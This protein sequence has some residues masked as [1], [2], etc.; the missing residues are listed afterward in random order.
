MTFVR[1][2]VLF[3]KL[4]KLKLNGCHEQQPETSPVVYN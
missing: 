1:D 3:K 4:K 2:L